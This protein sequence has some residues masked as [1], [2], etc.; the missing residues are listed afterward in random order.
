LVLNRKHLINQYHNHN[1]KL[2]VEMRETIKHRK[3][4]NNWYWLSNINNTSTMT[5][6]VN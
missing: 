5:T 2:V 1:R 6:I 4:T 3:E